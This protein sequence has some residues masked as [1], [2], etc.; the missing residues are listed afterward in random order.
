MLSSSSMTQPRLPIIHSSHK[1]HTREAW[2]R[3]EDRKLPVLHLTTL[4]ANASRA[5]VKPNT[6]KAMRTIKCMLFPKSSTLPLWCFQFKSKS[7]EQRRQFVSKKNICFNCVNSRDHQAKSCT[8]TNHRKVPGCGKPHHSL[9]H[10]SSLRGP[11]HQSHLTE[12]TSAPA[13]PAS[14]LSKPSVP[15]VSVNTS[16]AQSPEIYM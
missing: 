15:T 6:S 4:T 7:V 9:L 8:S 14:S 2:R 1:T 10:Q 3:P 13:I 11:D 5:D 16:V 12:S